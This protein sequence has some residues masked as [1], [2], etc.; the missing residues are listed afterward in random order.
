MSRH[1]AAAGVQQ[2]TRKQL[3]EAML[4]ISLFVS[5]DNESRQ[6]KAMKGMTCMIET[7]LGDDS[8]SKSRK[9]SIIILLACLKAK[10][11]RDD[12]NIIMGRYWFE[13]HQI[14]G[15]IYPDERLQT[16]VEK[17]SLQVCLLPQDSLNLF[18][19]LHG[20]HT[21]QGPVDIIFEPYNE[22]G[23]WFPRAKMESGVMRSLAPMFRSNGVGYMKVGDDM[24]RNGIHFFSLE[25]DSRYFD[26]E[27]VLSCFK[28][29]F[30]DDDKYV[31]E[32][33]DK[34]GEPVD[35]LSDEDIELFRK[36]VTHMENQGYF[37]GL[38]K[39]TEEYEDKFDILLAKFA[40]RVQSKK[41][42]Q[43]QKQQDAGS[44]QHSNR[45]K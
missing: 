6:E 10:G 18:D 35:L 32:D 16:R 26:E 34:P 2:D 40:E 23:N 21:C 13:F 7:A 14:Y 9:K 36:F 38:G 29:Y 28:E 45:K 3:S 44:V 4:N 8:N 30:E 17:D 33:E 20:F 15:F 43:A 1:A 19:V 41:D 11:E 12:D 22:H 42:Q 39:G 5:H 24:N 25:C 37:E 31:D 27:D